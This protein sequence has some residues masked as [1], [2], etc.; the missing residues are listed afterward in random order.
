L[1]SFRSALLPDCF[2]QTALLV[3]F[4]L[5]CRLVL[6]QHRINEFKEK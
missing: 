1:T 3:R 5:T 4:A 2:Q 6:D